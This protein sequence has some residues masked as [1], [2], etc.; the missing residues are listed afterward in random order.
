MEIRQSRELPRRTT[1]D[2][3]APAEF[4]GVDAGCGCLPP[5]YSETCICDR[6]ERIVRAHIGAAL[7]PMTEAQRAWCVAEI[8]SIEGWSDYQ[9]PVKDSVLARDVLSAWNDYVRDK[10][11]R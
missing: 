10:G 8:R 11:L 2:S 5:E 6:L 4:D 9:L 7:A 3:W 1:G